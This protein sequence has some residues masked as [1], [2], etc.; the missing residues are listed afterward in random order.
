MGSTKVKSPP[1]PDPYQ[2]ASAQTGSNVQTAVANSW[3]QNANEVGP[4]GSVS[5]TKSGSHEVKDPTSGKTYKVPSFTRTTTLDPAQQHL[6]D[7]QNQLGS[8]LNDLAM[9]QVQR[10]SQHLSKP[11]D[12]EGLPEAPGDFEPYRARVEAGLMERMNPQL[13]RDRNQLETKLVNQG[14]Q[15]GTQ[16]FN[17]AMDEA[18][19]QATDA[20]TQMFLNSGQ[21]ARAAGS[22]QGNV[23]QNAL[24]ER[25]AVRNQPISEITAL[26]NGGQPN[27]PQFAGYNSGSVAPTPVGQYVYQ[28]AGLQR[29]DAATQAQQAGALWNTLGNVAGVGLYKWCDRRLKR[30]IQFLYEDTKGIRWY[31][32]RYNFPGSPIYIGPM[33]QEL[34]EIMPDAVHESYNGFLFVDLAK[35]GMV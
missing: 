7:Q 8:G 2:V 33:A 1:A 5:Y 15:R 3:L 28:T 13:D 21:E 20:R 32:F 18:N 12:L 14:L 23:R 17:D 4:M 31:S 35:I 25:I 27:V 24:Q 26:M 11:M 22:Y 16:A 6:L 30:D 19:R 34:R 29:Q 9:G 10:L